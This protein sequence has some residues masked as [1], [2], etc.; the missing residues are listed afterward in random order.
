MQYSVIQSEQWLCTQKLL[1]KEFCK[2]LQKSCTQSTG[3]HIKWKMMGK[4]AFCILQ[5][6][7]KTH[8][9][10]G[11]TQIWTIRSAIGPL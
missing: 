6:L 1:I 5:R 10:E 2:L 7:T 11:Q 4:A 3:C 9:I 8:S